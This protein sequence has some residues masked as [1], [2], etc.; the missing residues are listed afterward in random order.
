M[1]KKLIVAIIFL[2]FIVGAGYILWQGDY[3][4]LSSGGGVSPEKAVSINFGRKTKGTIKDANSPHWYK[5]EV[6]KGKTLY[7]SGFEIEDYYLR[8]DGRLYDRETNKCLNSADANYL[9]L[10]FT[11]NTNETEFFL[12]LFI[13]EGKV[14]KKY[15]LIAKIFDEP[16]IRPQQ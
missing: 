6:P 16:F 4:T 8:V 11:N 9:E 13:D 1:Q 10:Q 15:N 2:N 12:S 14:H 7:I 3:V 5:V